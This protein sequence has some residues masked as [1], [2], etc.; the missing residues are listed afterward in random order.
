MSDFKVNLELL[1]KLVTELNTSF[2]AAEKAFSVSENKNEYVVDNSKCLGLV[3]SVAVEASALSQD[4]LRV[5]KLNSATVAP[6]ATNPFGTNDIFGDLFG[7][8]KDKKN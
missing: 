6:V 3:T 7:N 2:A 1:N 4:F 5:I 8:L